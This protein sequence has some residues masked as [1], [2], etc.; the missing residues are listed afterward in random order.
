MPVAL[1]YLLQPGSWRFPKSVACI[2]ATSAAWRSSNTL[3]TGLHRHQGKLPVLLT[4]FVATP[5][6]PN[7]LRIP[8]ALPPTRLGVLPCGSQDAPERV[9]RGF[10]E[11]QVTGH[12][13]RSTFDRY[14]IV[15]ED[16][17]RM[18]TQKTTMYVDTLPTKRLS[19]SQSR[20]R[21]IA[22]GAFA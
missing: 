17:L 12:V 10:G 15:S 21:P 16:D 19:P 1:P 22:V 14:N 8:V 5:R 2:I 13:T 3:P 11:G 4:F 7:G 6:K 18:A 9:G 20:D